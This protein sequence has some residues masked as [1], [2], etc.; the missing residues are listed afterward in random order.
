MEADF[1]ANS[2][3]TSRV[4]KT[5]KVNDALRHILKVKP[6]ALSEPCNILYFRNNVKGNNVYDLIRGDN[7]F[8][9]YE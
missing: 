6:D 8:K 9:K 1:Y 7:V 3:M 5:G 2:Y 4:Q